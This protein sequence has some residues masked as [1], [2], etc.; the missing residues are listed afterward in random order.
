MKQKQCPICYTELES[1]ICTPCHDCGHME[2][3]VEAFQEREEVYTVYEVDGELRLQLC[4]FCAVDFGSY[5]AS[6]FGLPQ[7]KSIGYEQLEFVASLE[8]PSLEKDN[9]CPECNRRLKF[10]RFVEAMREKTQN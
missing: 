4:G 2:K 5:E 8:N 6:Y 3:Q 1:V 7:G 10:L 9:Y